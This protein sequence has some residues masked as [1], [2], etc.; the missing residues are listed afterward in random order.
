MNINK[1]YISKKE[2]IDIDE[3]KNFLKK[4]YNNLLISKNIY[5]LPIITNKNMCN[6]NSN[7][8]SNINYIISASNDI[9][10]ANIKKNCITNSTYFNTNVN[11]IILK[12]CNGIDDEDDEFGENECL[13][14]EELITSIFFSRLVIKKITSNLLLLFGFM[15]KCSLKNKD[16]KLLSNKNNESIIFNSYVNGDVF[17]KMKTILTIRQVFELFYTIICCYASYGFCIS[18]INLENFMNTKDSFKT[19]IKVYDKIFYFQSYNSVCIIDYQTNNISENIVNLKKF[20]YAF[21]KLL[22]DD[23][24]REL[25]NID[26]GDYEN[27]M[28]QLINCECFKHYLIST[29]IKSINCRDI[30]FSILYKPL[31]KINSSNKKTLKSKSRIYNSIKSRINKFESNIFKN[32]KKISNINSNKIISNIN[33]TKKTQKTY[34]TKKTQKTYNTKKTQKTQKTQKTYNTYNTKKTQ[35]TYNTKKTQNNINLSKI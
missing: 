11:K 17:K 12:V 21:S 32:K 19:C 1:Y 2:Y 22:D 7:S 3:Y 15:N 18:D 29:K 13:Y 8:L 14:I 20:I 10:T 35:K 9:Y 28:K 6:C 24:K 26:S 27:V 23:I 30:T 4:I 5:D 16:Y 31:S 33:N 25:L 34:N